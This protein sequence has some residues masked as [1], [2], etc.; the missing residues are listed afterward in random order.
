MD[1]D[2][3]Q[4]ALRRE[5]FEVDRRVLAPGTVVGEHAHPF[6][7]RALVL[8]GE[9]RLTL[10]G[11][12]YTYREGDIFVLPAGHRHAE[13]VGPDGV[14]YLVGRKGASA[15]THDESRTS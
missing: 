12:E 4:D 2:C 11:V 3:F 15:S 7:V 1:H 8:E 6:D 10:D 9:I 13:A 14:R 5:G